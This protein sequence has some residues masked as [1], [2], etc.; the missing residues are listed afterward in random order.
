MLNERIRYDMFQR[1]E[2]QVTGLSRS[3]RVKG[4]SCVDK[5][6]SPRFSK[7]HIDHSFVLTL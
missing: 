4:T 7:R 2:S 3:S 1:E 5:N 6:Q